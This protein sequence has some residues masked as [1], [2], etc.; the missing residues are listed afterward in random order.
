MIL[1]S[2]RLYRYRFPLRPGL[3]FGGETRS[4]REGAWVV[5]EG[6]DGSAGVGEAAPLPG[7]SG[8]SLDE[9]V[10]QLRFVA[11]RLVDRP[12][13]EAPE[14]LRGALTEWLDVF[15][16]LPSVRFALEGALLALRAVQR[17]RSLAR[18]LG[19]GQAPAEIEINGAVFSAGEAAVEEAGRLV[20]SGFR[21]LKVKVGRSG[22]AEE[23]ETVRR[24]LDAVGGR[25]LLRLDA[26]RTWTLDEAT[27]F[28]DAVGPQVA[29]IE[30]PL[31][32]PEALEEFY[33]KTMVPIALDETLRERS[34][35]E[36]KS[37]SG[38]EVVV[39]KPTLW[40]GVE[41]TRRAVET[42]LRHGLRPVIG[43]AFESGVGMAVLTG[44][45]GALERPAPAG[46]D[47]RRW[48]LRDVLP[49]APGPRMPADGSA[50]SHEVLR[51]DDL[52]EIPL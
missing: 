33:R 39:L 2:V 9:A 19:A 8:E 16:P 30:E 1:R 31:A 20:A 40:G 26:N 38:V 12:A 46:L 36:V 24:I 42:A 49:V 29:S 4:F 22:P 34:I 50:P 17:G 7:F 52:Q 14:R 27:A 35:E 11:G 23:A 37:I 44:I 18:L 6:P 5:F 28:F 43:S 32:D 3:V 21:T 25:A 10:E 45:V 15:R 48:F 41:R 47:T 13:P 51:C